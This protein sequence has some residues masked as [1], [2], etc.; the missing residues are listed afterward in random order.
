MTA[1][2]ISQKKKDFLA[3]TKSDNLAAQITPRNCTDIMMFL[4]CYGDDRSTK[5]Q[6]VAA[7]YSC[8][9]RQNVVGESVGSADSAT[10]FSL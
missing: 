4:S 7:T 2:P 10:D 1:V 8:L 3:K 5:T 6:A 9:F